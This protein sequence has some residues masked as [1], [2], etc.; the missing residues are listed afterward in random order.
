MTDLELLLP[1]IIFKYFTATPEFFLQSNNPSL[2][3]IRAYILSLN[4][5]KKK[6]KQTNQC[7]FLQIEQNTA[8][9]LAI[10]SQTAA[11]QV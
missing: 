11:A 5:Q 1:F 3:E 9:A 10:F 7:F 6:N 8:F 4:F 2:L